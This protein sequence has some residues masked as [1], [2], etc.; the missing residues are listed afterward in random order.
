MLTLR[1]K[2]VRRV[3]PSLAPGYLLVPVVG[4]V[5]I[6]LALRSDKL[7]REG[8]EK[9]FYDRTK[10]TNER[11]ASYYRPL[12]TR[13]G[14]LAALRARTQANQFPIEPEL[15]RINLP[16]LILW[17]AQ[18]ALIPLEAGR[19]INS[20]IK[21]SRLVI[22]D[23]CGHLPQEEM[24]ARTVIEITKFILASNQLNRGY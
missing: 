21:D 2:E 19:K 10:I 15:A 16:T 9:S 23:S 17:G 18:D 20:L 14:Q 7:V 4:R 12:Q 6:A 24:P 22:F 3:R 11:V 13:A 8:L 5:L 1:V